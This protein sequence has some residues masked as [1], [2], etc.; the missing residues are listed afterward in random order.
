MQS[1]VGTP[2]SFHYVTASA[3]GFLTCLLSFQIFNGKDRGGDRLIVA[4]GTRWIRSI[5]KIQVLFSVVDVLVSATR[6]NLECRRRQ[7]P[8]PRQPR[9]RPDQ[10]IPP[11]VYYHYDARESSQTRQNYCGPT[12]FQGDGSQFQQ[13]SQVPPTSSFPVPPSSGPFFYSSEQTPYTTPL[14]EPA[15]YRQATPPPFQAPQ[16]GQPSTPSDQG[17]RPVFSWLDQPSAS[18]SRPSPSTP[19]ADPS[20]MFFSISEAWLNSPGLGEG[21]S[22]EALQSG[23][24]QFSGPSFS[25]LPQSQEAPT[26]APAADDQEVSLD[27]DHESE[28]APGDRPGDR[29]Y[30]DLTESSLRRRQDMGYDM[31]TQLEKNTR[32][33]DYL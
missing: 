18:H 26:T 32:C 16:H 29:Q 28:G 23:S 33:R 9:Q 14:T 25:L 12:Q 2:L 6:H 5:E 19:V 8:T 24:I 20:Q 17:Y 10:P 1:N 21:G 30:R 11:P 3:G 22:F 27:D 7:R 4:S 15:Q 13:H 31:R